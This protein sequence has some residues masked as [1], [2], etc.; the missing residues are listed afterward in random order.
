[1]AAGRKRRCGEGGLAGVVE[2]AAAECVCAVL[3]GDG[4]GRGAAAARHGGSEVTGCPNV[5]EGDDEV[6]AVVEV[7]RLTVS[8]SEVLL[9]AKFVS[10][11]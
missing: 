1:M 8:L 7:A 10:P 11:L 3:E 9:E 2:R 4:A 5:L 6:S